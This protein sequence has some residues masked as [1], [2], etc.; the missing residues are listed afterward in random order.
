MVGLTALLSS[1]ALAQP[2]PFT[3]IR[4][5]NSS[6]DVPTAI[7]DAGQVVVNHGTSN[8][9]SI[10]LWNRVGGAESL[11][12]TGSD[13]IGV[14]I[15]AENDVAG[16]GANSSGYSEAFLWEPTAGTQWLGTLGGPVSAATGVNA[17][18]DVVGMAYTAADLQHAFLWSQTG[19]MQDLTPSLTSLG[20]A[21]A[22]GINTSGEVV[23]YYYPNGAANVVGF[24]WTQGS[25]LQNFGAPGTMALAVNDG[26]TIVGQ[27]LTSTGYRHAFSMT[28]AGVMTDLGTLG[29]DMSTALG[30]SNNGWIVGTSL[31]NNK[32][33]VLRGFLWTPSGGMQDLAVV[34]TLGTG[35]QP[36]SL[37]VNDYGDIAVT[38]RQELKI[39]VPTMT[40]TAVSSPNPSVAGKA[41]TFT[42][43]LSSIAGPPP[44]GEIVQCT[45]LGIKGSGKLKNGVAKCSLSGI[46]AG[47]WKVLM[48]YGGDAYYLPA[49]CSVSQ[50]V[51]P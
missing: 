34:S 15:N 21:L 31:T 11:D 14:A 13:S 22:T 33:G 38:T 28:P 39:L 23:G 10:S 26:G 12:V 41:V 7:N 18:L 42:I 6:P 25:G 45:T 40:A 47:T 50:V 19:G 29:G 37:Q 44:D 46:K 3:I 48:N 35:Q 16:V 49:T 32:S 30:I 17:G 9:F 1:L 4:V 36:Y 20:G 27:A 5:P 51:N 24:T 2:R 8:V 43:T